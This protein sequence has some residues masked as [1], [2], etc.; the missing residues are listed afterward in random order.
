[1]ISPVNEIIVTELTD[2]GSLPSYAAGGEG[3]CHISYQGALP[4]CSCSLRSYY[5]AT[6]WSVGDCL[7]WRLAHL[8]TLNLATF[9]F[10]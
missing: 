4:A 7:A 5:R 10:D 3:L 8:Q 6:K 9:Y 2:H 1:M